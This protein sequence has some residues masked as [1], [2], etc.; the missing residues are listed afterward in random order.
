MNPKYM[1]QL[2][3]R[4]KTELKI[5]NYS[6]K[7]IDAYLSCLEDYFNYKQSNLDK[8]DQG[9]IREYLLSKQDKDYSSQTINLY[10]NAIKYF[11]HDVIR[12]S[13]TFNI[14]FAKRNKSLPVVLSRQEIQDLLATVK[15][16]KHLLLLTLSYGA[17]LRVSEAINLK[18]RDLN[19][20]ELTIHLKEA[21][22][23][24]DRITLVPDKLV[25]NLRNLIAGKSGDDF[26]FESER[27]GKLTERTAQMVFERALKLSSVNKEATFHSL[28]HSFATHLLENGT[29]IR[30]VQELL[31]HANIR[32]TQIY[33]HVT[34]PALK[35]IKSPL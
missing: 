34:N 5:R 7:T 3:E 26:V 13:E 27:G 8:L 19:L 35:N 6:P 11:Y 30:F 9:N 16:A 12:S 23:K 22:G 29:D 21:K 14:R 1:Q 10:L 28:R 2:L 32:T 15:N 17:G 31:G 25:N 24:K 20:E 18:V 33:T 4:V